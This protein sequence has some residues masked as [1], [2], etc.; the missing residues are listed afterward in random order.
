MQV[1]APVL[2]PACERRTRPGRRGA[3]GSTDLLKNR[4]GGGR[5]AA[6]VGDGGAHT[7]VRSAAARVVVAAGSLLIIIFLRP[8]SPTLRAAAGGT[9]MRRWLPTRHGRVRCASK[10]LPTCRCQ[11]GR[12]RNVPRLVSRLRPARFARRG[13]D[14]TLPAPRHAARRVC[15]RVAA[16]AATGWTCMILHFHGCACA[17][18]VVQLKMSSS[19]FFSL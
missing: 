3:A 8:G 10:P 18:S 11:D 14:L 19:H 9:A 5:G 16:A 17:C 4:G 7:A 12:R 15:V 2:G 1:A 6:A 13:L